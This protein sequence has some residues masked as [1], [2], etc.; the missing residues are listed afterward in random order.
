MADLNT[1]NHSS[2]FVRHV[3]SGEFSP[4]DQYTSG[5]SAEQSHCVIGGLRTSPLCSRRWG[6]GTEACCGGWSAV[7]FHRWSHSRWPTGPD[8]CNSVW[9]CNCRRD[10]TNQCFTVGLRQNQ[11]KSITGS[12]FS[13]LLFIELCSEINGLFF[14]LKRSALNVSLWFWENWCCGANYT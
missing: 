12:T 11:I 10:K 5:A 13:L 7:C 8:V 14:F 1:V 6:P 2:L 3:C 9:R 4:G